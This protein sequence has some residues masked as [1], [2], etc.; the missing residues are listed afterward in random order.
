MTGKYQYII[1]DFE[2]GGLKAIENPITEIGLMLVDG[3]KLT[4]INK[5]ESYIKPY[6]KLVLT[7]KALE[8][9]M[10]TEIQLNK[11]IDIKQMVETFCFLAKSVTPKGDKGGN[12]PTLVGHNVAF[13]LAFLRYAFNFCGE[14]LADYVHSNQDEISIID[15]MKLAEMFWREDVRNLQHCCKKIG[16]NHIDAHRAM[17]DVVATWKLFSY[18]VKAMRGGI[19]NNG[20]KPVISSEDNRVEEFRSTF[21]F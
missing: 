3:E 16:I 6:N 1:L 15:T 5:W 19:N 2:T 21:Q 12:K 7:K 20:S 17:N 10:I 13:D 11:G 18:F 8:I 14:N 4:E 9:T